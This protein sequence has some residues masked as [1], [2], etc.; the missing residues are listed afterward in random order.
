MDRSYSL[1]EFAL[2]NDIGVT[3]V[4][5]EIKAGRLTAR[6]V[7]R[8]TIIAAE[9]AKAWRERLPKLQL[10]VRVPMGC[11]DGHV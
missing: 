1:S 6:K 11:G 2:Q 8:R 9:D 4:R 5:G 10:R 3:T 7:G